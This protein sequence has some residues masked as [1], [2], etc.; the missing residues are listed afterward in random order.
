MRV[1]K[2][3]PG[4][5]ST[6]RPTDR[7]TEMDFLDDL[8]AAAPPPSG[9]GSGSLLDGMGLTGAASA[10]P[11]HSHGGVPSSS[12]GA[13]VGGG[14]PPAGSAAPRRGPPLGP[15]LSPSQR[16]ACVAA[17]RS[18]EAGG[19]AGVAGVKRRSSGTGGS[20]ASSGPVGGGSSPADAQLERR[21]AEAVAAFRSNPLLPVLLES[22]ARRIQA[23]LAQRGSGSI[24]DDEERQLVE[25]FRAMLKEGGHPAGGDTSSGHGG[26]LFGS[27]FLAG[28]GGGGGGGGAGSSDGDVTEELVS[29]LNKLWT[30]DEGGGGSSQQAPA[31]QPLPAAS[32][33]PLVRP[34]NDTDARTMSAL[35]SNFSTEEDRARQQQQFQQMQQQHQHQIQSFQMQQAQAQ[36]QAQAQQAAEAAAALHSQQQQQQRDPR[37][38]LDRS[39]GLPPLRPKF[40][41]PTPPPLTPFTGY[42]CP[43]I[44]HG[45]GAAQR[46]QQLQEAQIRTMG[47]DDAA[48]LRSEL[49]WLLPEYPAL[50][51]KLMRH[52]SER[53]SAAGGG[54]GGYYGGGPGGAAAD[55]EVIALLRDRAFRSA[56]S[57]DAE[58]KVLQALGHS[59]GGSKAKN[60][61]GG[62][63]GGAPP[64][65]APANNRKQK[66]RNRKGS[67]ASKQQQQQQQS[68]AS[69]RQEATQEEMRA[70]RIIKE[71][72]LTPQNLPQLV[73]NNP[74]VANE[75]LLRVLTLSSSEGGIGS[76][77]A[78]GGGKKGGK[79]KGK[80]SGAEDKES[81][82]RNEYLSALV[83]MDM[84]LHSME[85]VHRLSMS[86]VPDTSAGKAGATTPLVH[87][88]FVHRFVSNCMSSCENIQDRNAQN[89]L[90][91]LVCVFLQSLIRNQV[92]NVSDLHMEIQAFCITFSRIREAAALFKLLKTMQ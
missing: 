27:G 22:A 2:V 26:G 14:S 75:C 24:T 53:A 46:R 88:E 37:L 62:G 49:V 84:S 60:P 35:L 64:P 54:P 38:D 55:D 76:G 44:G 16:L 69:S 82:L 72:G 43:D 25:F 65:S 83:G 77:T 59:A 86:R 81:L 87:P 57:P 3:P 12:N 41:R 15:I 19:E 70:R 17:L 42:D 66:G 13:H 39:L 1:G 61:G 21:G 29:A 6:D 28:L 47:G 73:E 31:K 32:V 90:V 5:S 74:A 68:Q 51:L 79:G 78:S 92:V 20:G 7:P 71:C 58:R 36:A 50:R 80:S 4:S 91:R 10:S 23:V 8:L 40:V 52:P 11:G 34:S 30:A 63:G 45:Y 33:S 67:M 48:T 9:G 89:R 56:L 18:L 85:V